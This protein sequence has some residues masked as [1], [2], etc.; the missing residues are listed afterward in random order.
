MSE[1]ETTLVDLPGPIRS[2]PIKR[3]KKDMYAGDVI[4]KV[5][6][7]IRKKRTPRQVETAAEI[8][9]R[10]DFLLSCYADA[11]KRETLDKVVAATKE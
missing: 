11:I 10:I 2:T 1:P 9:G 7:K 8:K 3:K 6:K 4:T 5:T